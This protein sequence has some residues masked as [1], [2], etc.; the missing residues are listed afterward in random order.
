MSYCTANGV[1]GVYQLRLLHDLVQKPAGVAM[2]IRLSM[3]HLL[4]WGV[5]LQAEGD[6]SSNTALGRALVAT[7]DVRR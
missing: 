2:V 6:V 7:P 3:I 4:A 5:E 1:H